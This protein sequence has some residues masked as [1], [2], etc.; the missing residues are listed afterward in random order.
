[1]NTIQ[2]QTLNNIPVVESLLVADGLGIKHKNLLETIGKY[3]TQIESSFGTL[4]FETRPL[5][6][7]GGVQQTRVA[8]LTEGQFM[9]IGALSRNTPKVLEFKANLVQS[10]QKAK[11]L[12]HRL[13]APLSDAELM[14]QALQVANRVTAQAQQRVLMLEAQTDQQQEVIKSQAPKVEYYDKVINAEGL[15]TATN[16]A[17]HFGISAFRFNKMLKDLKIQRSVNGMWSLCA[18]YQG[19]GYTKNCPFPYTG[20]DGSERTKDRM[21]WT[22][23]GLEF[24]HSVI[25]SSS[26]AA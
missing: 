11:E 5:Q 16:A 12:A 9:F 23:K 21:M 17:Q 4:A 8:Y 25:N 22:P 24:L 3:Q 14:A 10:F 7:A 26:N 1:M 13:V 15:Y 19:K 20:A 6:T 2:L 18:K